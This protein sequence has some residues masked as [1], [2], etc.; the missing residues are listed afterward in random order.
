L[1]PGTYA[2]IAETSRRVAQYEAASTSSA[3]DGYQPG[4]VFERARRGANILIDN[5]QYS[6]GSNQVLDDLVAKRDALEKAYRLQVIDVLSA[7][8]A[9]QPQ[10]AA[11]LIR[12]AEMALQADP[13]RL[14]LGDNARDYVHTTLAK[15]SSGVSP[16]KAQILSP[17]AVYDEEDFGSVKAVGRELFTTW[18]L[19]F[20][21]TSVLLLA[22]ILG[23]VVIAKRRV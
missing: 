21:A 20:E 8:R 4:G 1:D 9:N 15:L 6:G 13:N 11:R 7:M 10:R 22:G 2:N 14:R 23:A 3:F 19:P 12:G 18:L 16:A 5:N 17:P